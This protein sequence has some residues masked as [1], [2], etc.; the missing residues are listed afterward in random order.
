MRTTAGKTLRGHAVAAQDGVADY[1]PVEVRVPAIT[2]VPP[3]ATAAR[4]A[5]RDG[6]PA[7]VFRPMAATAA[8]PLLRQQLQ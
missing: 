3:Q 1:P 6:E 4:A 5:V 7:K 2:R 8:L